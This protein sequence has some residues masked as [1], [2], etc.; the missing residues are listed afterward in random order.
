MTIPAPPPPDGPVI[1]MFAV[2]PTDAELD[3]LSVYDEGDIDAA[4]AWWD[5]L[6]SPEWIGALG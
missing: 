2:L 6:A 5:A 4:L 3:T 1:P